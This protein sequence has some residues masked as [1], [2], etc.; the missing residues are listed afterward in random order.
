M[1]SLTILDTSTPSMLYSYCKMLRM[2]FCLSFLMDYLVTTAWKQACQ[3]YF[4]TWAEMDELPTL[5]APGPD[6]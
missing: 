2:C 6:N 4:P 1:K 3:M 5:L